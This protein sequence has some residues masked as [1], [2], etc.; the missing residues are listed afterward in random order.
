MFL[1]VPCTK[2][3]VHMAVPH[4][5]FFI[6]LLYIEIYLVLAFYTGTNV[7]AAI[8]INTYCISA[9]LKF[10]TL[11]LYLNLLLI[12]LIGKNHLVD[13]HIGRFI[14]L[15]GLCLYRESACLVHQVAKQLHLQCNCNCIGVAYNVIA[16]VERLL[17]LIC[18]VIVKISTVRILVEEVGFTILTSSQREHQAQQAN[19]IMNTLFHISA[20]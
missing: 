5:R 6:R 13:C 3:G 17:K 4:G 11:H 12:L 8:E 1:L 18:V 16:E 19:Y 10:G 7:T 2:I 9:V 20:S 14:A 15:N